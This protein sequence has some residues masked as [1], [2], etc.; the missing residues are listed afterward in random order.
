MRYPTLSCGR[1]STKYLARVLPQDPRASREDMH[2][3][4]SLVVEQFPTILDYYVRGKEDDGARATSVAK[5]R[6]AEVEARFVEQVRPFISELLGR[7]GIYRTPGTT[8]E[9]ARERLKF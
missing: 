2:K 7:S 1:R 5:S 3:A 8:Y 4:M 6:V 9:E